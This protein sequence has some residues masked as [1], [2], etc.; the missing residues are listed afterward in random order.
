MRSIAV[1]SFT[2]LAFWISGCRGA[3][4]LESSHKFRAAQEAF[5]EATAPQDFLRAATQYQEIRDLGIESG[6]LL[7][8]QGN[9]FMNAGERGRAIACYRQ[10]Q[11]Y[12]PRDPYLDAN[13][14]YALGPLSARP[15]NRS[16]LDHLFFWQDWI[17]YPGKFQLTAA[18]GAAALLLGVAALFVRFR[19]IVYLAW[20]AVLLT[21]VTAFSAAYDWHRYERTQRGVIVDDEVTARKGNADTYDPAFTEPLSEGTEFQVLE[22]RGGWLL[23]RLPGSQEGWVESRSLVVY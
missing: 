9:A 10:A 16:V 7:Y 20:V 8:N 13:L 18:C 3:P 23:I 19:V 2:A 6:A 22:R 5:D 21:F 11:R 17:S 14:K 1:F 15:T 12:R 4:D